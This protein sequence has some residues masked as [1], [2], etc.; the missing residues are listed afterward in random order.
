LDV[1]ECSLVAVIDEGKAPPQSI[2]RPFASRKLSE[3][4]CEVLVPNCG[5]LALLCEFTCL[6]ET[7]LRGGC[8]T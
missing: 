6:W 3:A 4:N 7:N 5:I 8:A 1:L 2:R